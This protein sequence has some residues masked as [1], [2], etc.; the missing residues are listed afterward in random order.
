ML[1]VG[2]VA[3]PLDLPFNGSGLSGP[4]IQHRSGVVVSPAFVTAIT[5]AIGLVWSGS[6]PPLLDGYGGDWAPYGAHEWL[7]GGTQEKLVDTIL[8]TVD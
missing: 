7:R 4:L 1:G 6:K 2:R 8:G 3:N 5:C